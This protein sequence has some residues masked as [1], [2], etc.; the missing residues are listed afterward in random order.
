MQANEKRVLSTQRQVVAALGGPAA[1]CSRIGTSRTAPYN[2]MA[3]VTWPDHV[4]MKV[5]AACAEDGL[6]LSTRLIRRIPNHVW[7]GIAD[8]VRQRKLEP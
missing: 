6:Q 2:Y 5:V 4:L 7:I 8:Y 3:G 1:F